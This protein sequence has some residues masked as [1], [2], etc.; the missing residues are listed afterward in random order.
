VETM[1]IITRSLNQLLLDSWDTAI[2]QNLCNTS[3][4][5]WPVMLKDKDVNRDL[6]RVGSL[7]RMQLCSCVIFLDKVQFEYIFYGGNKL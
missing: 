2:D 1:A 5:P 7:R 3:V 6:T 4:F